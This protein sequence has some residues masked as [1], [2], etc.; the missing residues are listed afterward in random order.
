MSVLALSPLAA[1]GLLAGVG[2]VV[3]AL[4]LVKPRTLRV[5]VPSVL[6]WRRVLRTRVRT[7]DRW[8]WLL[9]LLLALAC[10]ITLAV[11]LVRPDF[12]ALG[13]A[14][15]RTVLILDNSPS[16][17][18]RMHDGRSRWRHA[19]ASA[20]RVIERGGADSE[21]LLLDTMGRTPF[22]GFATRDE[23]LEQLARLPLTSAG[24]ARIPP[25]PLEAVS[26][27][28]DLF[29][30]GV[31]LGA[32]PR[33]MVVHSAFEPADNVALTAFEARALP[34]Q[35]TRYEALA[36]IFNASATAKHVRLEIAGEPAF[37]V[38]RQIDLPAGASTD[39][40]VDVSGFEQ[41]VLR[42]RVIAD[43][44][45][46]DLDDVAYCVV[47]PHRPRRVLL[48]TSGNAF[49][50]DSIRSL[51]GVVLTTRTPAHYLAAGGF[52]AYVFDRFAP[53][54]PPPAGA[55]LFRPPAVAWIPL[56]TN[57]VLDPSVVRWE[58]SHPLNAAMDWTDVRIHRALL[59]AVPA[60]L[61]AI[62]SAR[63]SGEG[64]LVVAGHARA[65]WIEVGF[66]LGDSNFPMQAGFPVF[67]G[68]ALSWL[69]DRPTIISAGLG[70]VEVP[71]PHADVRDSRE[72]RIA[73][74]DTVGGTAFEAARPGVYA[75]TSGDAA[76]TVVANVLDPRVAQINHSH[77]AGRGP[78]FVSGRR[79]YRFTWPQPWIVLL[80]A[81]AALLAVEWITFS[82]RIT[83]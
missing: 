28:I 23:A 58:R 82:R 11:A 43:G 2:A 29:T 69:A 42:A 57:A 4:Y 35:P 34:S 70:H 10:A 31:A 47:A 46:L 61:S 27:R 55:L 12:R 60:G 39:E 37:A 67:L 36:Q 30:D 38:A 83:V 1:Y 72:Q 20:R 3:L 73:T 8:R 48:V 22:T 6:L 33:G 80:L 78:E 62:V 59:A 63:G 52:D 41:G 81:G 64:A 17:A 25:L 18:A 56:A 21:F 50:E 40:T 75:V 66:A 79:S 9:S 54:H 53:M 49:L 65:A 13:I 32:A 77:L 19:M 26:T 15:S 76:L 24:A 74:R 14:A 44:D 68:S 45:A 71:L 51:P 7:P 5:V 16:M